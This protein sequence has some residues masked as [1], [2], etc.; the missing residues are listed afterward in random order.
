VLEPPPANT[1][2]PKFYIV[3]N[4][5]DYFLT[6]LRRPYQVWRSGGRVSAL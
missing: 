6:G 4:Y 2:T 1:A 3:G 5:G